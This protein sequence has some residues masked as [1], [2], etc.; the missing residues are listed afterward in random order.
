MTKENVIAIDGVAYSGKSTIA[1]ALARLTGYHYVN[2]GHM[3]RAVARLALQKALDLRD[4]SQIAN[5]ARRMKFEFK[6]K[7]MDLQTWVNGINWTAQ[8][9][10]YEIVQAASQIA[11]YPEV[12]KILTQRQRAFAGKKMIIVE[13][14][15]I[16]TTV[17]PKARWKFF[18]MASLEVRARRMIKLMSDEERKAKPSLKVLVR[19]IHEIDERDRQRVVSPL[20]VAKDALFY[21]NSAIPSPEQ[22]ALILAYYLAQSAEIIANARV[23]I[24]KR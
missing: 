11:A 18:I 22:D 15:D 21:D 1:S 5:L 7:G 17:F 6:N 23:L 4:P 2:T 16:G 20:R 12:R 9:D 19:R 8:L 3:Y 24:K 14:R 13:G 10:R